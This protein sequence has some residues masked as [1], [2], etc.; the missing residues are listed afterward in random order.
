MAYNPFLPELYVASVPRVL[1]GFER[2][3]RGR[4]E[5]MLDGIGTA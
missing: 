1:Q 2:L 5:Y 4:D 3:G